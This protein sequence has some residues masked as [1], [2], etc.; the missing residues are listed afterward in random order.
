M[1]TIFAQ[2]KNIKI[3]EEKIANRLALYA[4]NGSETDY[5]VMITVSGTN[6][7]QSK[8]KPRLVRVPQASKVH[9]KNLILTKGKFPQYTYELVVNDSLSRRA[10]RKPFT[11]IKIKPKKLITI[12]VTENCPTCDSIIKPLNE[13]KYKFTS[14]I[15]AERPEV[16]EGLKR[17]IPKIDSIQKPIVSLGG[18]IFPKV[19]NYD[20]LM[21]ELNK[22]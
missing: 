2:E 18:K 1:S 13:S 7:R 14:I 22:D 20:Q 16:K 9:L 21:V 8:G 11:N 3:V 4:I 6:F 17:V 15:L 12:Y 10:L 5:D 19:E